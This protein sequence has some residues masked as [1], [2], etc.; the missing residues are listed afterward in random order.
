VF[1]LAIAFATSRAGTSSALT[2]PTGPQP[3]TST[4]VGDPWTRP[5][6]GAALH[7]PQGV[8]VAL[9]DIRAAIW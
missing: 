6:P 8:P 1:R 3:T 7:Q 2:A 4:A 5:P 9:S